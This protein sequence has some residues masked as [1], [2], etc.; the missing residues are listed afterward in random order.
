MT[1]S[2]WTGSTAQR[3]PVGRSGPRNASRFGGKKGTE[4]NRRLL[5][6]IVI[7]AFAFGAAGLLVGCDQDNAK[8]AGDAVEKAADKAGDAASQGINS[9]NDAARRAADEA[10][11]ATSTARD[12]IGRAAKA[13]GEAVEQAGQKVK[14]WVSPTTLPATAPAAL[15]TDSPET[16]GEYDRSS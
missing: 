7:A 3:M 12:A 2:D 5:R 10:K 4:M 11:D 9:A 1:T 14:D 15:P 8:K 16:E 13:S 6:E